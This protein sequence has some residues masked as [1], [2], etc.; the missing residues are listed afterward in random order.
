VQ[1]IADPGSELELAL[2]PADVYLVNPRITVV[3]LACRPGTA[4]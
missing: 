1:D 3:P 2:D 4:A